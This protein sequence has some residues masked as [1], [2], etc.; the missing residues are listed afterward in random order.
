MLKS[1]LRHIF[2]RGWYIK[3]L[4]TIIVD[5]D[6]IQLSAISKICGQSNKVNVIGQFADPI[7]AINFSKNN[8]PDFAFLEYNLPKINGTIL[9]KELRIINPNIVI[10]YITD[11]YDASEEI[12][13]VKPDFCIFKP[14]CEEDIFDGI[15]RAQLLSSLSNKK[16][17]FVRTFGRFDVFVDKEIVY[18]PNKK[19]K[20]LLALCI[21]RQ[22][23]EITMEM[24]IDVLWPEKEYDEK[25]KRL[26]R[27]AVCAL[28]NTLEEACGTNFFEHSRGSCRIC[29]NKIKCDYYEYLKNPKGSL[30]NPDGE[31]MFQYSWAEETAAKLYFNNLE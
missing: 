15:K 23:G 4:K 30:V 10:I 14:Y 3:M 5:N 31:Y 7:E 9:A 20:E 13:R 25:A 29:V 8:V 24:A 6:P 21:D 26:Y 28:K 2:K 1:Y 27:K 18:F 16:K 11:N 17:I 19:S 12:L 22:G